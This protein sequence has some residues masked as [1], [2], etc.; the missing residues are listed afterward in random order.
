MSSS[1]TPSVRMAPLSNAPAGLEQDACGN[2]IP[3]DQRTKDDRDKIQKA[4]STALHQESDP[5]NGDG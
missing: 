1:K 2:P 3:F 4:I 5:T